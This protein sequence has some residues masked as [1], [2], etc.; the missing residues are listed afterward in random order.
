M[1]KLNINEITKY[2]ATHTSFELLMQKRINKVLLICSNYDAFMLEEDGRIDE[3]IFNEYVSLNL[4]H[5][6]YIIQATNVTEAFS[7]LEEEQ[8]ELII[9]MLN[10]GKGSA[11]ALAKQIKSK[12]NHIPIVVLTH[13]SKEVSIQLEKE[14][15]SAIDYV[16]SW[17]GNSEILL[18]IIKLIEDDMN[19]DHDVNIVGVQTILLVEDS[20]RFYS[21]Y[22][23]NIYKII[24]TQSEKFMTEGVNAHQQMIKMRGRPK[25]LLATN[26]EDAIEIFEKYKSNML[27]IIS[28]I[29]YKKGEVKDSTAGFKLYEEIRKNNKTLPFLLQSSDKNNSV[30][31]DKIGADFI[32]KNTSNLNYELR[33]YLIKSLAFGSF[34]F[35]NYKTFTEICKAKNL[36]EF[37]H[38][39]AKVPGHVL[40]Y[41][42]RRNSFARWLNARALFSIARILKPLSV[43]DFETI[44]ELRE[45]IITVIKAYRISKGKG[46]IAKFN[47]D[48]FDEYYVFS[49]I[50]NGSIGGKARGLA[51]IDNIIKKHSLVNKYKNI[52][53]SI[54]R[55]IVIGTDI[56]DDFMEYNNLYSIVFNSQYTD[57]D[58]LDIFVKS[59]L[60]DSLVENITAFIH[61]TNKPLAIRSSSMLEDS[62]YQPFAGVYST[63]MVPHLQDAKL[64]LELVKNAIKSVYASVY[65]KSSKAY[66]KT[67]ANSID[68]EK[69]GIII[70]EV[71]GERHN[72]VYYPTF[73]G[74]ARSINFYPIEP[75]KFSEGV[76]NI[77]MGLGKT[78]VDGGISLRFSPK[79]PKKIIQFSSANETLRNSQKEFYALTSKSDY[80]PS[81]DEGVNF[82]KIKFRTIEDPHILKIVSSTYDYN[83]NVVKHSSV[84]NGKKIIT[85][86]HVLN[87]KYINLPEILNDLLQI[88]QTEMNNPVEIEFACNLSPDGKSNIFNVLQIRP[89]V[90]TIDHERI[91]LSNIDF[92]K[93]ILYS[94]KALG[95]GKIENVKHLVYIKPDKFDASK[96][97]KLAELIS[98]INTNFVESSENYALIGPGRWGS[99]DPWLGIP[100]KWAQISNAALIIESGI[101]NFRVDPSQ[102][103]HFFQNLTSFRIGY[104]TINSYLNDGNINYDFLD[105]QSPYYEDDY[106]KIIEFEEN[107][108]IFIDGKHNIGIVNLHQNKDK[109]EVVI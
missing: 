109:E 56:F 99:S 54:P 88:S 49:R 12:Y 67:T 97:N 77:A 18:A 62:H 53:F 1:K 35:V 21:A 41:Y 60:P 108:D 7:L 19:A 17:L 24:F 65:Y 51:F 16:F 103:T 26:Y 59:K 44:K 43:E 10:I 34:V 40:E 76:V 75:E 15:L 29:S 98:N 3:Q 58:L 61:M 5:P 104:F 96:S 107:L 73:S 66:I 37:Q 36:R 95:N 86:N 22:L 42:S 71:C 102:G 64:F 47:K 106:V 14:D 9:T 83:D 72:K 69:M 11:F 105:K 50:G 8:F 52:T 78:I 84:H 28:D 13:F 39:I 57:E 91:N 89:I 92:S 33:K 25:I 6:P 85:F 55:T 4:R 68:E 2:F 100:V 30:K 23:P 101:E 45:Y 32:Y 46:I 81:V 20:I 63:Y 87:G 38:C 90:A 82:D 94:K 27:G 31:A 79:H 48:N 74:V 70:Q 80:K 93:S